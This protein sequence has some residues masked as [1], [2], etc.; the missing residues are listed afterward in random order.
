MPVLWD[1]STGAIVSNNFGDITIDLG[2]QFEQWADRSVQLYPRP[3]RAEIDQ[4]DEVIYENV[5]DGAY[6]V[7][8]ATTQQ[9]YERLRQRFIATLDQLDGRLAGQR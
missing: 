1:R 4:L 6:R 7:A 9:E 2:T 3:L 8:G 5:N